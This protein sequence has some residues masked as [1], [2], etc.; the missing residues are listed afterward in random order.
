[1]KNISKWLNILHYYHTPSYNTQSLYI[2]HV[3]KM[4]STHA[5]L[6]EVLHADMV[7]L[8]AQFVYSETKTVRD[9]VHV[10]TIWPPFVSYE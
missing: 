9:W 8:Y 1:M 6:L 5:R 10:C 4:Y 2:I 3:L 7:S